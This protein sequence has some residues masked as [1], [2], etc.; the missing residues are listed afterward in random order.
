MGCS[1]RSA[2]ATTINVQCFDLCKCSCKQLCGEEY[3]SATWTKNMKT[4]VAS[5]HLLGKRIVGDFEG[6]A[7]G[8][9]LC[10]KWLLLA[11]TFAPCAQCTPVLV[12]P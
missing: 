11:W 6:V 9:P 1:D 2:C 8:T 4:S 12:K 5:S 10:C 7:K 3:S